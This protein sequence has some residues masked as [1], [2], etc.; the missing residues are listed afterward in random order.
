MNGIS[1]WKKY[2]MNYEEK[3]KQLL[4]Q[5]KEYRNAHKAEISVYYKIWYEKNKEVLQV[6]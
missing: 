4:K 5:R 6:L 1:V 3:Y 2:L